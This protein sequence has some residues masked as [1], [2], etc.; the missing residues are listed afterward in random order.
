M[1][2]VMV[3]EMRQCALTQHLRL[4]CFKYRLKKIRLVACCLLR[5]S[6]SRNC[7][8]FCIWP[9]R[10]TNNPSFSIQSHDQQEQS[11][12]G[13]SHPRRPAAECCRVARCL[14]TRS[15]RWPWCRVSGRALS[16]S[17]LAAAWPFQGWCTSCTHEDQ[18]WRACIGTT[19]W[20]GADSW[21]G[22]QRPSVIS[23]KEMVRGA[24]HSPDWGT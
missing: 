8:C 13:W 3:I 19:S 5:R 6:L 16:S 24:G 22:P 7:S 20:K 18:W 15:C 11:G 23:L 2:I 12:R 1:C 21:S 10:G 17:G 4:N 14:W 9:P